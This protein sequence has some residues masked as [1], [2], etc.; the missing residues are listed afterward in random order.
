MGRV[1][2]GSECLGD[3]RRSSP[4]PGTGE[5]LAPRF[6]KARGSFESLRP[7]GL[8]SGVNDGAEER[9]IVVHGAWYMSDTHLR[10]EHRPPPVLRKTDER[11]RW[12]CAPADTDREHRYCA[13]T[14]PARYRT[15]ERDRCNALSSSC[16]GGRSFRQ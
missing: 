10:L 3:E 4:T 6:S 16:A 11:E 5:L 8:E 7:R 1:P 14:A 15:P 13:R 12:R 2:R 9:R